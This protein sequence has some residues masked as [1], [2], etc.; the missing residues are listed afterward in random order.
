MG[1][2]DVSPMLRI[3][4]LPLGSTIKQL[5]GGGRPFPRGIKPGNILNGPLVSSGTAKAA[6]ASHVLEHLSFEDALLAVKNTHAM[7]A[8]GGVFRLIVPDLEWRA[9]LYI[10]ELGDPKAPSEFVR[11]CIF[12][13][14]H[15]MRGIRQAIR[16]TFSGSTHLWMWDF[17]SMRKA[18]EDVGF[19]QVRRCQYGDAA[20]P[21]F[22]EVENEKR[23][24]G[25]IDDVRRMP[26]LA[27]EAIK[28]A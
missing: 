3:E 18:L 27:I 13:R 5:A 28:A 9:K 2:F 7:L 6:Y 21:A 8:I 11:Q 4:Q 26:E 20:D 15:R 19:T 17:Y 10:S 14:E 23:F 16:K 12:G 24:F 1:N 22:A 25:A